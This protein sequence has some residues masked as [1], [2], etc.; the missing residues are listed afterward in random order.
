VYF[1]FADSSGNRFPFVFPDSWETDFQKRVIATSLIIVSHNQ[2]QF[3]FLPVA[4][5][6][7]LRVYDSRDGSCQPAPSPSPC[8]PLTN[9]RRSIGY[10]NR[11]P[12]PLTESAARL[13]YLR[14]Y[15][16]R[17]SSRQ[18]APSPSPCYTLT[19]AH[20]SI[21]YRNRN[22]QPL[23]DSAARLM[24]LRVYDSRDSSRQPAPS[25]SPCYTLTHAHRSILWLNPPRD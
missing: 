1:V 9:A 18:P 7:Y 22:P 13:M 21:G 6:M 23:T 20:R 16:S 5:L 4:R 12:Q 17:D 24:Y 15:D 19:H 10:R 14:V 8:F 11:N 25:P 3:R 2:D